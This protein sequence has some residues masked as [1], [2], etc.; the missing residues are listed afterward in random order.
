MIQIVEK[1]I[2]KSF[3][4]KII[5]Q[6]ESYGKKA[7]IESID[8]KPE[9]ILSLG[10]DG[11]V[12]RAAEIAYKSGAPILAINLGRV[13]FLTSADF[14]DAKAALDNYFSNKF[15]LDRR[16]LL[17]ANG[18]DFKGWALNEA[19]LEKE[20]SSKMLALSISIDGKVLSTYGADGIICSTATGSTA[21][22]FSAGGPIMFPDVDA[23]E[24]IPIAAH[25]LFSK[26]IILGKNSKIEIKVLPDSPSSANVT[27]DGR[28]NFALKPDCALEIRLSDLFIDF[29]NFSENS[30]TSKIVD[31]FQL[32]VH[33]W[34]Y[35]DY[36]SSK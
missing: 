32:P 27:F 5:Q 18:P 10:G 25:A 31:K 22:A 28:R 11:T 14:Q 24:I 2:D 3:L 13:G 4:D 21:H 35:I 7:T 8:E 20:N 17:Y 19:A 33:E 9:L 6:I 1:S 16:R 12:L 15:A 29:V 34:R 23:I 26:P 30:F 36:E